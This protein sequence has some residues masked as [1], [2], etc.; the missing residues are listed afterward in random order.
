[1]KVNFYITLDILC[2]WTKKTFFSCNYNLVQCA[3]WGRLSLRI[4][5]LLS[6]VVYVGLYCTGTY[7]LGLVQGVSEWVG[8]GEGGKVGA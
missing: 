2:R 1:M 5:F 6:P 4:K 3:E 8:E 7:P